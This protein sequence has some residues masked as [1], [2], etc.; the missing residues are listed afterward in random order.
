M[1]GYKHKGQEGAPLGGVI[2]GKHEIQL[3][4]EIHVYGISSLHGQDKRQRKKH[5]TQLQV[6]S[7]IRV[8]SATTDQMSE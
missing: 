8:T 5:N 2:K 7:R 6:H 1:V 4:A 3:A